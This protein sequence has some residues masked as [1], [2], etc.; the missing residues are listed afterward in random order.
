MIKI[1]KGFNAEVTR[2]VY[3]HVAIGSD[4]KIKSYNNWDSVPR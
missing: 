3:V 1:Q 2:I 4:D